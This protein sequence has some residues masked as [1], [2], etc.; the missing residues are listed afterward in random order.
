MSG[1]QSEVWRIVS[2]VPGVLA[3]SLGRVMVAPYVRKLPK[4]GARQYGGTPTY[5]AED[6][7]EDG[8]GA[9]MLFV[10]RRNTYRVHSLVCEAFN[11]PRPAGLVCCHDDE[12]WRNNTPGNLFWGTQKEN[13]NAPGFVAMCR[14]RVA[15]MAAEARA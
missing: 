2:S 12:N 8:R 7:G 9:R 14:A 11:G 3:S 6:P 5:G 13:M 1:T 4:G 15:Q 10:F